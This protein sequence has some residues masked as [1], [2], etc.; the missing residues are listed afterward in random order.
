[1]AV[2]TAIIQGMEAIEKNNCKLTIN[3]NDR[4]RKAFD[5]ACT[6]NDTTMADE[7]RAFIKKRTAELSKKDGS[8]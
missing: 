4:V 7:I 6:L 2:Y 8:K 5:V 3:M 1:M